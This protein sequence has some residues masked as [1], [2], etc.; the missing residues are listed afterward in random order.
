MQAAFKG[1]TS[2]GRGKKR[3]RRE[4][5]IGS[6]AKQHVDILTKCSKSYITFTIF[7]VFDV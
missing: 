6:R 3:E 4:E 5:P 1:P 7:V 2:K